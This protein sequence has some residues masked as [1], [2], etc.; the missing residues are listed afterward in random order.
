MRTAFILIGVQDPGIDNEKMFTCTDTTR[1][2]PREYDRYVMVRV[3]NPINENGVTR[4]YVAGPDVTIDTPAST[5]V[6]AALDI[7]LVLLDNRARSDRARGP[8]PPTTAVRVSA[9]GE[10]DLIDARHIR[11]ASLV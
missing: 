1:I 9:G 2:G 4:R 11:E 3:F 8:R 6:E 7:L 5:S 10:V